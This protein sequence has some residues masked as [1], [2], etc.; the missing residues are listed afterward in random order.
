MIKISPSILSADFSCLHQ[1]IRKVE[2]VA[3]LLHLDVMDGHFVP[4]I[5]FGPMVVKCLRKKSNLPIEVHL[6]VDNPEEWIEPFAQAGCDIIIVHIETSYH[7]DR[8][9]TSIKEREIKAGVALNPSTPLCELEY[10]LP[11]LDLVLLMTVN[12]GFGAQSFLP[13]VLPKIRDL[14]EMGKKRGLSFEIEVD[15]GINHDTVRKVVQAGATILVA[16][17]AVFGAPDPQKAVLK[18]KEVANTTLKK[19]TAGVN[20]DSIAKDRS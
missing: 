5:T 9:I 1:E 4:N 15:G 19:E 2:K 16:G 12:P 10:I 11:R 3:D 7:L 13:G 6:M 14:K 17:I 18:L 8:L 20:E